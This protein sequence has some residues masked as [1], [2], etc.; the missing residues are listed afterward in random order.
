[1]GRP[2]AVRTL[3][4]TSCLVSLCGLAAGAWLLFTP[5]R[6]PPLTPLPVPN[7]YDDLVRAAGMVSPLP[8][9]DW[10][11]MAIVDLRKYVEGSREGLMLARI[12]L[13]RECRVPLEYSETYLSK[14][15]PEHSQ[16]IDLDAAFEGEAE[17]AS[18]EGDHG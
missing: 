4:G 11:D 5:S 3:L 17:L 13:S 8:V 14:H 6:P 2:A 7:G 18:R 9:V 10:K 16:L 15:N 1:M 12:G